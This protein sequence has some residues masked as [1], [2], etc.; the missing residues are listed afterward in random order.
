[1]TWS[2]V[3]SRGPQL[4]D[5]LG[6]H[7][8]HVL[9]FAGSDPLGEQAEHRPRRRP[10]VEIEGVR[11]GSDVIESAAVERTFSGLPA[12]CQPS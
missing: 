10:R 8:F 7:A 4:A 11:L 3:A 12:G 6:Q 5:R 1:M 2:G 9:D